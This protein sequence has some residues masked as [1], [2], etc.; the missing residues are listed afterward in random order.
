[1]AFY[2]VIQLVLG[3]SNLLSMILVVGFTGTAL[4]LAHFTGTMFRDRVAGAKWIR[5]FMV[6]VA[7][8]VWI[9]L[10]FL[11]FWVRLHSSTSSSGGSFNPSVTGGSGGGTGSVSA[12]GTIPGAALF[13]G[14]YAATGVIA[15]VGAYLTHNPLH[16]A[17]TRAVSEHRAAAKRHATSGSRLKMAEAEREFYEGQLAAARLVR[18]EAEQARRAKAEELKQLA[19]L[20]IV[21]R[22]RD[23][24]LTDAFMREDNQPFQYRPFP[25]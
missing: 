23:A 6:V 17:F 10:G 21:K 3:N 25:N 2:Q 22:L 5:T 19:R 7:A 20:E 13:A 8:V 24:S 9:A 11:A 12:Q 18:D 14:L 1:V 15:V 4:G 16:A